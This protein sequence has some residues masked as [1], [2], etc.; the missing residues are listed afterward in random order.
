[1]EIGWDDILHDDFSK[2][3]FEMELEDVEEA[4]DD[5]EQVGDEVEST[6]FHFW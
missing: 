6:N 3:I 2:G 4:A 5:A 1:M